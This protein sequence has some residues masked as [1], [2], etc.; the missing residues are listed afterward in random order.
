MARPSSKM[1]SLAS[2]LN[3]TVAEPKEFENTKTGLMNGLNWY[4]KNSEIKKSKV[5]ALAYLQKTNPAQAKRL[6]GAK[7]YLFGNRGYL[8]RMISRGFVADQATL[9]E[10]NK[11]F[12][13]IKLTKDVESKVVVTP[14]DKPKDAPKPVKIKIPFNSS[15]ASLDEQI[16][17]AMEGRTTKAVSFDIN[18]K[19]DIEYVVKKAKEISKDMSEHPQDYHPKTI[20]AVR[21]ILRNAITDAEKILVEINKTKTKPAESAP[22]NISPA[23]MVKDVRYLKEDPALKIKSVPLTSV[24]G[25]KKC[26]C[27]DVEK[28]RLM[29]FVSADNKGLLFTGTTIKNYDPTKSVGKTIRKPEEFFKKLGDGVTMSTINT[30]YSAINGKA[31]PVLTGR[32]NPSIVFLK[33]SS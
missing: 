27:Y 11:F 15:M 22:K 29:L 32:T 4:A 3:G 17:S 28:R 31:T 5:W 19:E 8:C 25:A 10:L 12:E 18:K 21:P 30:A 2:E 20:K 33:A 7:D 1:K 23:Q 26:Y 13:D 16:D 14:V 6:A 24:V 9:D